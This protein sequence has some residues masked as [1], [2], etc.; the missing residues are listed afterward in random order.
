VKFPN[1]KATNWIA[2]VTAALSLPIIL[3]G[4]VDE[5]AIGAG[6]IP[7]RIIGSFPAD[8]VPFPMVPAWLTPFTSALVHADFLHLGFNMI[9]LLVTGRFVE[10]VIGGRLLVALYVLGAIGAAA[11]EFAWNPNGISPVIGAS[12]AASALIATY[13]MLYG[14]RT[15][16]R[17]GPIPAGLVQVVWL[18]AGWTAINILMGFAGIAAFTGETDSSVSIGRIAVAAH[19]GGFI[20]GLIATRPML[21]LRFRKAKPRLVH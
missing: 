9:M 1:G 10:Q 11:A 7:A 16:R 8:I 15:A 12:G 20:V 13:A 14:Q 17:I 2:G 5:V 3:V 21:W 6:F 18:L 19:I 4:K